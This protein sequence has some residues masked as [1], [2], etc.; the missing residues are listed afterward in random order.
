MMREEFLSTLGKRLSRAKLSRNDI[1]E[2]LSFYNEAICERIETGTDEA[3]A[4]AQLGDID[5]IVGRIVAEIPPVPRAMARAHSDH[6]VLTAVLLVLGS[7]VWLPLVAALAACALAV[8]VSIWA[9]IISLWA[10]VFALL[11]CGPCGVLAL[12]L[13]IAQAHTASAL[14]ACGV[15]L[16]ACGLGLAGFTGVRGITTYLFRLTKDFA[17]WVAHFFFKR[18]TQDVA[19]AAAENLPELQ[20]SR[21]TSSFRFPSLKWILIVA[22]IVFAI[23]VVLSIVGFA[24]LGWNMANVQPIMF[25]GMQFMGTF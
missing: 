18:E 6:K 11:I 15:G 16:A 13:G 9:V 19:T 4:V 24:L 25:Q 7:P 12:F 20:G 1:E 23:G 3:A 22:G 2:S 21:A 14:F 17:S 5:L 8:Y 10:C